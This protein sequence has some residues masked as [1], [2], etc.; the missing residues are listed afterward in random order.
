MLHGPAA[1][2]FSAG[3]APLAHADLKVRARSAV[4]IAMD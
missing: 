2:I 3:R 4:G 1:S